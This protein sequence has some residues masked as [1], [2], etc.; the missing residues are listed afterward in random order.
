LLYPLIINGIVVSLSILPAY[1]LIKDF[2]MVGAAW[3]VTVVNVITIAVDF[4]VL[5]ILFKK[6]G[7]L[8]V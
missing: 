2:G 3:W 4:I 8:S 5:N 7:S 1:I 6:T